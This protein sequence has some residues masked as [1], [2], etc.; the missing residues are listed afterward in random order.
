MRV[1][2]L[3][4]A[5]LLVGCGSEPNERPQ[6][7]VLAAASLTDVMT[8]LAE[9]FEQQED[10]DVVL[11]FGG[12]ST[13]AQQV[14]SGLP[15]DVFVAASADTM[16]VVAR[17]GRVLDGPVVVA[18]N[19]LQ[20]AVPPGNP[21]GVR[22]LRDLGREE[23][24]IALCAPQVPCGAAATGALDAAGV[25]AAPDTLEQDVRAVLAKVR[26]REVDA[27]VVYVTDVRAAG[28]DVQG[29]EVADATPNPYPAAVLDGSD[30]P[31]LANRFLTLLTSAAGRR[32]LTGAGFAP[33]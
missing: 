28:S 15:A 17:A 2:L 4:V 32:V 7:V 19:R 18:R 24:D 21:A 26:L 33:P 30:D 10:V 20:I 22:G 13:L 3:L 23:L 12:S 1:A 11:S 5:A 31:D 9:E 8:E 29:V 14:L 27:G 25:I 16:Q 6:L